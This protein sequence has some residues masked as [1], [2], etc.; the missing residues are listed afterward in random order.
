M[1][2]AKSGT[3]YMKSSDIDC[4]GGIDHDQRTKKIDY[5]RG[6]AALF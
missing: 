1:I 5:E 6:A 3:G 4:T 2:A